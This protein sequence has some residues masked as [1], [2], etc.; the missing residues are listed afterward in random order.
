VFVEAARTRGAKD[1]SDVESTAATL[2]GDLTVLN[3]R[4]EQIETILAVLVEQTRPVEP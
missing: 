2:A 3:A 1:A 4:L